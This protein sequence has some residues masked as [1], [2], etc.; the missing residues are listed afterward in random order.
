MSWL[1]LCFFSLGQINEL[2]RTKKN[3]CFTGPL[4]DQEVE[5]PHRG[6]LGF[7]VGRPRR[8]PEEM[9]ADDLRRPSAKEAISKRPIESFRA[10]CR[11]IRKLVLWR[12]DFYPVRV[13]LMKRSP[14]GTVTNLGTVVDTS[15]GTSAKTI[16]N[17]R[18]VGICSN[19]HRSRVFR[20]VGYFGASTT[21]MLGTKRAHEL[22]TCG[23]RPMS[24]RIL[25]W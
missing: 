16:R 19:T 22:G 20:E 4:A 5:L 14:D 13:A 21:I 1:E 10:C 24:N 2:A 7:D 23:C 12:G 8:L 9:I 11:W 6:T 3:R 18:R 25:G 15:A 17:T